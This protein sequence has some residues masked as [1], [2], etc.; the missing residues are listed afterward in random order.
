MTQAFELASYSR[1]GMVW[2]RQMLEQ[3]PTPTQYSK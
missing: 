1:D 2:D 3:G